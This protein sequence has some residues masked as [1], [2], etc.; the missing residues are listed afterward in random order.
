[1]SEEENSIY[2]KSVQ[3]L[4]AEAEAWDKSHGIVKNPL[5]EEADKEPSHSFDMVIPGEIRSNPNIN[6]DQQWL[7]ALIRNLCR[8]EGYCWAT[9]Q[10]LSKEMKVTPRCIQKYI[11]HLESEGFIKREVCNEKMINRR[12]IWISGAY[13][14]RLKKSLITNGRSSWLR[15]GV[16]DEHEPAFVHTEEI[17][18]YTEEKENAREALR[19]F[20][21]F[22]KLSKEDYEKLKEQFTEERLTAAINEMNDYIKALGKKP[23]KDYAAAIRNW[24]R[25]SETLTKRVPMP[26]KSNGK[27]NST[28]ET[29]NK[30]TAKKAQKKA[31]KEIGIGNDYIEFNSGPSGFEQIKFSEHGFRERVLNKLRKWG[32]VVDDL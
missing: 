16:H 20:G 12:R 4:L 19:S 8:R 10:Y 18:K 14:L 21:D 9:N 2:G 25:R 27:V 32:I 17:Y 5:A 13:E 1:M 31:P 22:V 6:R 11:E 23:Y 24:F 26:Q 29:E 30:E 15:T 3:H 7:Y 28:Q